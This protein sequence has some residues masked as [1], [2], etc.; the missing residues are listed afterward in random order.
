MSPPAEKAPASPARSCQPSPRRQVSGG[1]SGSG[2]GQ[3]FSATKSSWTMA[4]LTA[5]SMQLLSQTS[6]IG[7]GSSPSG[8]VTC[9]VNSTVSSG[10]RV[11]RRLPAGTLSSD[12]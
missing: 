10:S 12:A 6:Q 9:Q 3:S 11:A 5:E 7:G 8:A 1:E 4:L 2:T